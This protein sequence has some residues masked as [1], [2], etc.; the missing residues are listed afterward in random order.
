M[1]ELKG[2]GE[3]INCQLMFNEV[4]LCSINAAL[5]A[6]SFNTSPILYPEIYHTLSQINMI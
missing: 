1:I 5:D 4:Q 2:V 3:L 6:G